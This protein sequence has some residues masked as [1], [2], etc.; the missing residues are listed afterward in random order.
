MSD[1]LRQGR[2]HEPGPWRRRLVALAVLVGLLA[3]VILTHLPHHRAPRPH[4]AAAAVVTGPDG[5]TGPTLAWAPS[6]RVPVAT[7]HPALLSPAAGRLQLIGGLPLDPAGYQFTQVGGG[8]AIQANPA[9]AQPPRA[10]CDVCA[11]S[12]Q[13]VYF[14]PERG[15]SAALVAPADAVAPAAAARAMWLT[16]YPRGVSLQLAA[17]RAREVGAAGRLLHAPVRLP[18]GYMIVRGTVRGL[19]LAA[20]GPRPGAAAEGLLDPATGHLTAVRTPVVAASA[21]ELAATTPCSSTSCH[22]VVSDLATGRSGPVALP[23]GTSV[24][25]AAFSPDGSYLALQVN[26]APGG[27]DGGSA[28]RLEVVATATGRLTPVPDTS[29]SSDALIGFGWPPGGDELVAELSFTTKVQLAS[30]RPG[31]T[32]LAVTVVRTGH[33]ADSIFTG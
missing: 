24:A 25:N 3:A 33:G 31:A 13:P 26:A 22:L 18:A 16:S 5:I 23:P 28:T 1:I 10:V 30:W 7:E 15:R 8:W 32:Q 17:G 11:G 2:D 27:A 20:V 29:L 6:L 14:L 9:R 4:P 12:P 21:T 19:L